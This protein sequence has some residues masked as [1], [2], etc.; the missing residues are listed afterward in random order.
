MPFYHRVYTAGQLQFITASTYR[1][2]P[3]FLS[4]RFRRCFVQRLEEMRRELHFLLVGWVLMPEHFHVPIRPEPAETTLLITKARGLVRAPGD[5]PWSSW[6]FYYW[7]DASN[8][9]MDRV[10]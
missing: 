9:R 2:T 10:H 7:E 4:D 1:R 8:L 5:R 6:R 3:L